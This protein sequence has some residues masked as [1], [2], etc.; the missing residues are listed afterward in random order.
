MKYNRIAYALVL[1]LAGT[2]LITG[3]K[4]KEEAAPAP[5]PVAIEPA[6]APVEAPAIRF[7]NLAVGNAAAEDKSVAAVAVFAPADPII[8]SVRTDGASSNAAVAASL[9]YQ[10]GQSVGPEQ[11]QSISTDGP[12][13]TNFT[14]T[15][16]NPWPAGTYTATVTLNG[17]PAGTQEIEV[18]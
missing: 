16:A 2:V 12:E 17:S 6:P 3:C 10:D 1:A 7:V 13:T 8:V 4:K 5:A 15:N 9:T 11:S 18:R 14:F